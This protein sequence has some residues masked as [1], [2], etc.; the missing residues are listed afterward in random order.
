MSTDVGTYDKQVT[1]WNGE[2]NSRI[3]LWTVKESKTNFFVEEVG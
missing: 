1:S 2:I 3:C